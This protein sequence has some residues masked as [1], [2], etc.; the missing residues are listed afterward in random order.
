MERNFIDGYTEWQSNP[1]IVGVNRLPQHATLMPY[2]TFEEAKKADRYASSRCKLLNGKWK[3]KLYKNYAY[4]PSDFADPNYDSHNWDSVIVPCSWQMQGY[5]QPQYCNVRYPWE[6][7]E[8]I[9]PPNAPVKH[10]PVGCYLKRIHINQAVLNRRVV[11][12]FEGVEAAFY[13]YVNGERV[14]YSE[15]TFNRAEFD[16][17]RHLVEGSNVIGVEVYRWCTGSWLECQDMWRLGGIFRDVYIYT[18]ERE[19][20]RDFEIH[21]EPDS[22]LHDG[23]LTVQVKTNGA[24][25]GLSI[26]MTVVDDDGTTAA[27]DSQY[28]SEEHVTDLKAIVTNVKPW[29]SETPHLYTIVL[30]L[31]NN[32]VPIE[33]IS[34]KI[35]FRTVEIKDG[36]IRI[37]GRR[38]VFKGTNRHE[39]DCHKG[40]Y[41]TEDV[42]RQDIE[43]MKKNNIN[44]VRTSH[45][46]NAP[47]WYELCDE[48]GLYVIDENNMETHG[49]G[50]STII[51]CPQLP[52]SRPEWEKACM[53]RIKALYQRDKNYS[54]VVCWSLGNESLGGE[55]PK[56]MYK[57]IKEADK[58][59][60][61]HFECDRAPDEKELSDV[62]S[63][64]YA[65]P[66]DCEEYALT[67]RDGRPY[68]L[69][70]YTHAMGN[71]C[72]ST[73]E[74]TTLW[75]KYPCLQ[76]GFVW[77][78]VDQSIMTTDE[79]GKEY[80][81]YG[82][83][84]GEN[85]HDGH[86]CG[87]GLLFGDRAVTPK[88][89][90]IKKLYQN[91]D[92]K[93]IDAERGIIEI[94]NKNLF[95]N[96]KEY[97]LHWSQCSDKGVF[98]EGTVTVDLEPFDKKTINLELA[99]ASST[100]YY[101]NLELKVKE[102]TSWCKA[103]HIVAE[104][105]F[106]I[107]EFANTYDELEEDLPLLVDDTYG[108][109]RIISD[110][111]N[112]RFERRERNQ[113][114]SIKVNGE[115]ML[116]APMRLNFWRALTDNDRGSRAGSRLGCWRDA[117]D[118]PGIFNNSKWRI[119]NYQI[120]D[121]GKKVVV[122]GG[123]EVCTQ[124]VSRAVVVYTI[125]SKGMEI[126][127]E[128]KPNDTLPEIPEISLLFELPKDFESLTYLGAGPDENYIDR[129][130]A[131]KIGLYST[132]V[133]DLWVDYLKPQECG[134]R[135]GV[136]YATLLGDK[137]SFGIVAEPVC[138][139]NVC[140]YLPKEIEDVWHEKDL[141]EYNKTVVR[142]IARQQGV[143]G[144]DSWGAH[145]NEK[146][147][148]KTDKTYRLKFQLRF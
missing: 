28:A 91:V 122:V 145:C 18:T 84:F 92:F 2:E 70:E 129:C 140:H 81:A 64:M 39:F 136:R 99:K 34:H 88:L 74:Y 72:G 142:V 12:C 133:N 8:D 95:T 113:L 87:N 110:D 50:W 106:V 58:S 13:L 59:R 103:G 94:K 3:F 24:Y 43:L 93:A 111:I 143:G 19:Y 63:K 115:E 105:Q 144:Y 98:S 79:N 82:G 9:C 90:E 32:G 127:L 56:K 62:Q 35:G 52:A 118:T 38:I 17:T 21:A 134:N 96:L 128:F 73:D 124:P 23:Y 1:E 83:D 71:S 112:I 80:L 5:D 14:G 147:K 22:Q 148:N 45:Y 78:W 132:T 10:N 60:F 20:I 25:E 7:S 15:S 131:A 114:Y 29:S 6:G 33:Y 16:I 76:G 44:A 137:K 51:G 100:E 46:P 55:T 86:F 36:I 97:D 89:A 141:P 11:L 77:D 125:T 67:G 54:C 53:E 69:C 30:T 61:V 138:E 68:I 123:A 119:E 108:S 146:Y 4:R 27:L 130:N 41:I 31:K 40:R 120:L 109:L 139:L 49:T 121:N 75:D 117:G 102:D 116:Q 48:Y 26:D 135:T 101:L 104:E 47:R 107:N 65:K 126:S 37:N 66:W 42:M 85:P 57:W